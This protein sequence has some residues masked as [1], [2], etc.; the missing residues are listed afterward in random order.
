MLIYDTT[1]VCQR[2][3]STELELI[4]CIEKETTENTVYMN[5]LRQVELMNIQCAPPKILS[6]RFLVKIPS[7]RIYL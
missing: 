1:H 5:V 6:V 3:N 2:A 4:N 7:I